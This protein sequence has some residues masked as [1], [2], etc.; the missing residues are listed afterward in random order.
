MG[1]GALQSNPTVANI[2]LTVAGSDF[3]WAIFSVMMVR[4]SLDWTVQP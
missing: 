4:C 2:D 3:L 1:N